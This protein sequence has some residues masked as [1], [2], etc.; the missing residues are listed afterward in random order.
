MKIGTMI[1]F[2][3]LTMKA[4]CQTKNIEKESVNFIGK[5][6]ELTELNPI[7]KTEA[8][9]INNIFK[10]ALE[11]HFTHNNKSNELKILELFSL[12][13]ENSYSLYDDSQEERRLKTIR[14]MCFAS[15]A[16]MTDLDKAFTFINYAKFTLFGSME[17][18]E[19]ELMENQVLGLL[20]I[21]V[22]LKYEDKQLNNND[23]KSVNDFIFSNKEMLS[24]DIVQ[25]AKN[26]IGKFEE[27]LQ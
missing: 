13:Y 4:Y 8:D 26:I 24:N 7:H 22:L 15:I 19:I 18:P 1:I 16:L 27:E 2:I 17:N 3:G 9:K 14:T 5:T 25:Q 10:V 23:L 11:I 21:E 12:L 6:L 20:L